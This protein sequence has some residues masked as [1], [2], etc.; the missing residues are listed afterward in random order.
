VTGSSDRL[1]NSNAA[2]EV[3]QFLLAVEFCD[4][5]LHLA[6]YYLIIFGIYSA[7]FLIQPFSSFGLFSIFLILCM[8]FLHDVP[9][10]KYPG[11]YH[12]VVN[13]CPLPY[14][15]YSLVP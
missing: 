12:P 4:F 9:L 5:S 15:Y 2:A 13:F 3:L 14:Q 10:A 6:N 8:S 1:G 11:I 7:I